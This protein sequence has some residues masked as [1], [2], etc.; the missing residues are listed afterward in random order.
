MTIKHYTEE[1]LAQLRSMPKQVTN[2]KARWTKK[3]KDKPVHQQRRFEAVSQQ[4]TVV[5]FSI[6]QRQNI[7]D[8]TDFSC[9]ISYKPKGSQSLT[10][11]RYNGFS[12]IHGDIYYR[13]HIH[14]TS[15]KAINAG[16]KPE[17]E[18]EETDRYE[19]LEG[20]FA[21]LAEDFYLSGI[22]TQH[23]SRRLFP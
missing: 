14:R 15:E 11:A 6:Y 17:S 8:E 2:P 10:L 20:A 19:T 3:P 16:R 13:P 21:C 23:D 9:G 7:L 1:E 12:H 5:V 18:A 4:D 22:D